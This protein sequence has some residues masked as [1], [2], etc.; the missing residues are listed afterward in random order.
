MRQTILLFYLDT[1]LKNFLFCSG[2]HI[3]EQTKCDGEYRKLTTFLPDVVK[4]IPGNPQCY[5]MVNLRLL[6]KEYFIIFSVFYSKQ[7]SF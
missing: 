7:F 3:F 5:I 1:F 4:R 6:K 2:M